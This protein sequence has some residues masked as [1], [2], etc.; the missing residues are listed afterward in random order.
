[1]SHVNLLSWKQYCKLQSSIFWKGDSSRK[2]FIYSLSFSFLTGQVKDSGYNDKYQCQEI[3]KQ[4]AADPDIVG[5]VGAFRSTCSIE[6]NQYFKTKG[7]N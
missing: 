5:I 6:L 7:R 2:G 3:A 1:M 4:F